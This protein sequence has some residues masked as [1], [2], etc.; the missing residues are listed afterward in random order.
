MA[1]C[2][3]CARLSINNS[4]TYSE[5]HVD[6]PPLTRDQRIAVNFVNSTKFF[7]GEAPK[8]K[9]RQYGPEEGLLLIEE[10]SRLTT[11]G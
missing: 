6:V 4:L 7:M 9:F 2:C 11:K 5:L 3:I 10:K 8:C 1:T